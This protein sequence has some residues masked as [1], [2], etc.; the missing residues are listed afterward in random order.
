MLQNSRKMCSVLLPQL[1]F[2][3]IP[4]EENERILYSEP[5]KKY[6]GENI[7]MSYND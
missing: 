2:Y 7:F 4:N 3:G 6:M 1:T 5:Y